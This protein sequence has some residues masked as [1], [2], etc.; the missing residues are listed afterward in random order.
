MPCA[1]Q[2]HQ[3]AQC[4]Q[5]QHE[6]ISKEASFHHLLKPP[7]TCTPH[8]THQ[9]TP[10]FIITLLLHVQNTHQ[11][12]FGDRALHHDSY[13]RLSYAPRH[14]TTTACCIMRAKRPWFTAIELN[15]THLMLA[16]LR[17]WVDSSDTKTSRFKQSLV[18][19]FNSTEQM[20][21]VATYEWLVEDGHSYNFVT[22]P[23]FKTMLTTAAN[24]PKIKTLSRARNDTMLDGEFSVFCERVS[25]LR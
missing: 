11:V 20:N 7:L 24:N 21:F 4:D 19:L 5:Q 22:T 12:A 14:N 23:A 3:T 10:H 8:V 1:R 13:K 15:Q 25:S 6:H 17:A 2:G 9:G 16:H 18:N